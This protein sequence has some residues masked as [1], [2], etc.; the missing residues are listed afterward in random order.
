[1][2]VNPNRMI[3]DFTGKPQTLDF[4]KNISQFV[5]SLG[6]STKEIKAQVSYGVNRKFIWFWVYEKTPDGTLYMTV[7][8]DKKLED[9]IFHYVNQVSKNRWNHH[10]KVRSEETASSDVLRQLV[11]AGYEFASKK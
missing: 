4:F 7:C 1:M 8:L 5:E 11:R 2:N 6:P 10:I 3:G 9:P